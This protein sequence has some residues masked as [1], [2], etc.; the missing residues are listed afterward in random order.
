MNLN[1]YKWVSETRK[2][3]LDFCSDLNPDDFIR[4]NGFGWQSIRET[5]VHIADCYIAWLGSFVL[6]KTKKP[7]TSKED[8][9][10]FGL[11]EIKERFELVDAY[12]KEVFQAFSQQMDKPIERA[13]PWREGGEVISMTPMKLIMHTITHE[14]HHKG[15]IMSMAR[16]M[17]YVPPNTDVLGTED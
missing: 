16:M 6:L 13:I 10:E 12:V 4:I 7:I 3:M 11:D 5:L 8:L 9:K 1:E 17:D 14:F 15:Q 2:V